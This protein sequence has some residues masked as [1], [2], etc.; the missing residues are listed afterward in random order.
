[1]V[2]VNGARVC[3]CD[4]GPGEARQMLGLTGSE[5][6]EIVEVRVHVTPSTAVENGGRA[7]AV[8]HKQGRAIGV[9]L[10]G[11]GRRTRRQ[12]LIDS[13]DGLQVAFASC[14]E[15]ALIV[16]ACRTGAVRPRIVCR[17]ES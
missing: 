6:S 8:G 7:G 13:A 11:G 5:R 17:V 16:N 1:M 3:N 4:A 10:A 2:V 14:N 9:L 12:K 15:V